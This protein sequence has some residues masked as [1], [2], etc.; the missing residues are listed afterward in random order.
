[1]IPQLPD[2][3]RCSDRLHLSPAIPKK[4]MPDSSMI[5]AIGEDPQHMADT[6]DLDGGSPLA[7]RMN[8]ELLDVYTLVGL[9][10]WG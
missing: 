2:S 3:P 5:C 4:F 8:P 6:C 1:M 7:C 10:S 9:S